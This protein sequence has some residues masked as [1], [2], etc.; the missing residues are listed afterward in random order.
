MNRKMPIPEAIQYGFGMTPKK[1]DEVLY[2]YLR[3]G[4]GNVFKFN[5]PLNIDPATIVV[6]KL[7]DTA[8]RSSLADLHLHMIDRQAQGI[9]EFEELIK[10]DA[11]NEVAHRGLAFAYLW[12]HDLD[13]ARPHLQRAVELNSQDARVH[14]YNAVLLNRGSQQVNEN[15][16]GAFQMIAELQRATE[17]DPNYAAAWHLLAV[18]QMNTQKT[19]DALASMRRAVA[20]SP[21]NDFFRLTLAQIMIN[22]NHL[23]DA[24]AL[25]GS[26]NPARTR[27]R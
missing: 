2:S 18:M 19:D 4:R 13:K 6:K 5:L 20:L 10:S 3:A 21:R 7:S 23:G 11:D 16:S 14:Y 9:S 24:K 22:S 17:L 27:R 8:A 25:L 12:K 1:F 15:D 26:F